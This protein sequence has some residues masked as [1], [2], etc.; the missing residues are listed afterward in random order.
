MLCAYLDAFSGLSGD[1]LVAALLGLGVE[2]NDFKSAMGS[3]DLSGFQLRL[4]RR[5]LSGI[6]A[7]KFDV[8]VSQPQPERHLSEILSL[9]DRSSLAAAVKSK[10]AVIFSTLAEAEAAIH[11]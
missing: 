7:T 1:M 9:I 2:F 6:S 11:N 4:G 3:L 10:A 8:E 5:E